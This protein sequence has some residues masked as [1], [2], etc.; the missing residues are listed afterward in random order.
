MDTGDIL[1]PES[2]DS[3][4]KEKE[5]EESSDDAEYEATESVKVRY[6]K[7][8]FV[9]HQEKQWDNKHKGLHRL[10]AGLT[11]AG[12]KAWRKHIRKVD[13]V[14]GRGAPSQIITSPFRRCRQ[15]AK[16]LV[17][18]Y[19]DV[20]II[21][22]SDCGEYLGHQKLKFINNKLLTEKTLQHHIIY[23]ETIDQLEDRALRVYNKYKDT[24]IKYTI[25]ITHGFLMHHI[26]KHHDKENGMTRET[27]LSFKEGEEFTIENT[28][29]GDF[30]DSDFE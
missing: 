14:L 13:G 11:K 16:D 7:T 3:P 5:K 26:A 1:V 2:D 25:V 23:K 10:D 21:V 28:I 22:D 8:V 17:V 30:S 20:Q 18:F 4:K 24:G 19:P 27:D 12:R 15:M 6:S 29:D 9:R